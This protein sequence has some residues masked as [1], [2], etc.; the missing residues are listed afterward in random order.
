MGIIIE[1]TQELRVL[2]AHKGLSECLVIINNVLTNIILM[3]IINY[4]NSYILIIL[5]IYIIITIIITDSINTKQIFT[6]LQSLI[7]C[8]TALYPIPRLTF[9]LDNWAALCLL[10]LSSWIL[11]LPPQ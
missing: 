5:T 3:M 2:G 7:S 8:L 11:H 6:G 1:P 4:V 9:L 10:C